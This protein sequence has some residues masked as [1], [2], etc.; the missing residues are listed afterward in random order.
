[1]FTSFHRATG[2]NHQVTTV[3]T[4]SENKAK[5]GHLKTTL[6][7]QNCIHEEITCRLI[8]ANAC[9]HALCYLLSSGLLSRSVKIKIYKTI[10]L[11]VLTYASETW[12]LKLMELYMFR[13]LRTEC[14]GECLDPRGKKL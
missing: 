5:C 4:F 3:N 14:L 8:S 9:Y 12:F 6:T 11:P 13:V 7:N 10:I 1:V 2:Q